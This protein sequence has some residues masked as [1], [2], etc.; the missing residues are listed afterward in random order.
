MT[1]RNWRLVF[2]IFFFATIVGGSTT[3]STTPDTTTHT[4]G[5]LT[6]TT[7]FWLTVIWLFVACL[8]WG[9]DWIAQRVEA[10]WFLDSRWWNL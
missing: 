2:L 8:I 4:I 10:L 5:S 6:L 1:T 3:A 7:G 9:P